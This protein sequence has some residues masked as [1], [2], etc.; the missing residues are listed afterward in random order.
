M[1]LEDYS[2]R[3]IELLMR[4][5][6]RRITTLSP[7]TRTELRDLYDEFRRRSMDAQ[8]EVPPRGYA[9]V[10]PEQRMV[11]APSNAC[12]ACERPLDDHNWM[13]RGVPICP[14]VA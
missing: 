6:V 7:L 1:G 9:P 10:R 11:H 3:E 12:K 5:G 13:K 14:Q 2:D 8:D 4:E